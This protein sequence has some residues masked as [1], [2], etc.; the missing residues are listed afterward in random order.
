MFSLLLPLALALPL[1]AQETEP[2]V[3]TPTEE[4]K[5]ESW[6]KK[7]WGWGGIPAV[8]YNS[9]EGF[10][11]GVIGSVYKYN[12][13]SKPYKTRI[14]GLVF[15][16]TKGVGEGTGLG[17]SIAYRVVTE[18]HKGELLVH[19]TEGE[20]TTFTVRIPRESSEERPE[21]AHG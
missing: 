12:G 21:Q 6:Q 13:E 1:H 19:S 15:F 9:D 3:D 20:G 10:G 16:T 7:K 17:L 8:N 14:G 5:L 11:F 18:Q 4:P 2:A